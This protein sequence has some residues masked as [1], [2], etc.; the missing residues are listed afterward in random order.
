MIPTFIS[1]FDIP[2][3][4]KVGLTHDGKPHIDL[5]IHKLALVLPLALGLLAAGKSLSISRNEVGLLSLS[6]PITD[7][8]GVSHEHSLG[9]KVGWWPVGTHVVSC[10]C[11]HA[12]CRVARPPA[13]A[14]ATGAGGAVCQGAAAGPGPGAGL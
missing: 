11:W 7:S 2:V 4:A 10:C 9:T 3:T 6:V 5:K 12:L 8:R 14:A 1:D 13:S